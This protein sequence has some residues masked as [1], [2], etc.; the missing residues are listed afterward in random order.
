M[1]D[2]LLRELGHLHEKNGNII[3]IYR[4]GK[5]R[6]ALSKSLTWRYANELSPLFR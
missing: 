3:A 5:D 1:E 2:K 6:E 4:E